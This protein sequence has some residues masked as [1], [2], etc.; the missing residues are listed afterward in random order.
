MTGSERFA[1]ALAR[2]AIREPRAPIPRFE[3]RQDGT[4]IHRLPCGRLQQQPGFRIRDSILRTYP[5]PR[6]G[7]D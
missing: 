7:F 6:L 2:L 3:M 4:L 1:I 5:R